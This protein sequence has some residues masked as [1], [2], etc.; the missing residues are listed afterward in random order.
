MSPSTL[1]TAGVLLITV[2]GVAYG[3]VTLLTFLMRSVPGYN[4]NRSGAASGGPDTPMRGC[5]CC[6]A[7]SRCCTST[8]RHSRTG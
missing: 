8:R 1:S 4:D 3:G 7:W 6:S 5:W 2:P